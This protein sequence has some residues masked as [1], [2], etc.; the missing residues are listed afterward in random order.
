M[1]ELKID[2]NILKG[3]SG[4]GEGE[5]VE[6]FQI[7]RS[8]RG[9]RVGSRGREVGQGRKDRK[10]GYV[11]VKRKRKYRE[12]FMIFFLGQVFIVT[13]LFPRI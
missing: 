4:G 1:V 7:S 3:A 8:P 11:C 13:F 12:S 6:A 2:R 9:V 10:F 5:E